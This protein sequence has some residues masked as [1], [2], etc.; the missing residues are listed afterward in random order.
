LGHVRF[1]E[2][3]TLR[4]RPGNLWQLVW[5]N[6]QEEVQVLLHTR[7]WQSACRG[8]HRCPLAL[9]CRNCTLAHVLHMRVLMSKALGCHDT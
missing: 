5:H 4:Q 7:S 6:L 3:D 1:E 2:M 8:R 9:L